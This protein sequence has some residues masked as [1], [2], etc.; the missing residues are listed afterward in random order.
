[1]KTDNRQQTTLSFPLSVNSG[2]MFCTIKGLRCF[3]DTGSPHTFFQAPVQGWK[4][5]FRQ[6]TGIMKTPAGSLAP[7]VWEGEFMGVKRNRMVANL[8]AL[9]L[10]DIGRFD[11]LLGLDVLHE[12]NGVINIPEKTLV[13]HGKDYLSRI[14]SVWV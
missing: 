8:S 12:H 11:V 9:F 3:V 4:Y 2:R 7:D 14:G 5:L 1:M 13:F 6:E 10:S